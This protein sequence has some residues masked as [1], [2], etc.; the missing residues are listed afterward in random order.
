M[1]NIFKKTG[2][3]NFVNFNTRPRNFIRQLIDV[4][5]GYFHKIKFEL[6]N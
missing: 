4:F 6:S 2:S 1:V 5:L 3:Y